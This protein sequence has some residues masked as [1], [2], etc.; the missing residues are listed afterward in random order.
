MFFPI[1]A[2]MFETTQGIMHMVNLKNNTV[3]SCNG[4]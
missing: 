3:C 1:T 2:N 4:I